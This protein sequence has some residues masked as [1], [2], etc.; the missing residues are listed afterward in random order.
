MV[1]PAAAG[2]F[3]ASRRAARSGWLF[4]PRAKA[5]ASQ[6]PLSLL[7]VTLLDEW[8]L[9]TGNG[10]LICLGGNFSTSEVSPLLCIA[11]HFPPL[12]R[13]RPG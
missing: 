1:D 5:I 11:V 9:I 4:T 2:K 12:K 13:L 8:R 7:L 6:H 10:T 3:E